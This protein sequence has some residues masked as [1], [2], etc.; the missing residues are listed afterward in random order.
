VTALAIAACLVTG[1]V[2]EPASDPALDD[3]KLLF[4][5][6]ERFKPGMAQRFDAITSSGKDTNAI[7]AG[8]GFIA[9]FVELA[10]VQAENRAYLETAPLPA[11]E[12]FL[13]E[14]TRFLA[15]FEAAD[16]S[17]CRAHV[18]GSRRALKKA[19]KTGTLKV[20]PFKTTALL[21]EAMHA[22]KTSPVPLPSVSE[23]Q[24]TQ[25]FTLAATRVSEDDLDA[26]ARLGER[27]GKTPYLG[28]CGDIVAYLR[29]VQAIDDEAV[30][31]VFAHDYTVT[32]A[33]GR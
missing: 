15:A 17:R 32:A 6:A 25:A 2:A 8:F 5:A 10:V 12:A 16:P 33:S 31:R 3:L 20:T 19:L 11:L 22:G 4:T 18:D 14:Q 28:I 13:A 24:E 23:S 9:L 21:I 27:E 26:I 1:S 29:L 30:R 7:M